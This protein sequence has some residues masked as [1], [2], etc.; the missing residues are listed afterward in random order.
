M[1]DVLT[2]GTMSARTQGMKFPFSFYSSCAATNTSVIISTMLLML[3]FYISVLLN[4]T[5][6]YVLYFVFYFSNYNVSKTDSQLFHATS[7]SSGQKNRLL[8]VS[9][10]RFKSTVLR[11]FQMLYPRHWKRLFLNVTAAKCTQA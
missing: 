11:N 6:M 3:F 7:P 2:K 10:S 4:H 1:S 8:H 9:R 5:E